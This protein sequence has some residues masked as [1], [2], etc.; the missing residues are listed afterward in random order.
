MK[1]CL[2]FTWELDFLCVLGFKK[3]IFFF[4]KGM[5]ELFLGFPNSI[6]YK[7]YR[8]VNMLSLC[9]IIIEFN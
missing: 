2:N 6:A 9:I 7:H 8:P 4:S 1:T 3:K 5:K